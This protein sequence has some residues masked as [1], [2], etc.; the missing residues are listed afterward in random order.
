MDPGPD[1]VDRASREG[2]RLRIESTTADGLLSPETSRDL[3]WRIDVPLSL[4]VGVGLLAAY[5]A[6]VPPGL[7]GGDGA[8][9]MYGLK[10]FQTVHSPG[11]PLYLVLG[12]AVLGLSG[13]TVIPGAHR[14]SALY[15]GVGLSLL[16]WFLREQRVPPLWAFTSCLLLGLAYPI[17]QIAVRVEVYSLGL[18]F[19]TGSLLLWATTRRLKRGHRLFGFWVGLSLLH[20]PLAVLNVL[21]FAHATYRDDGPRIVPI[22]LGAAPILLYGL[23]LVPVTPFPLNWP[24]PG[25]VG[26]LVNHVTAPSFRGFVLERG[27]WTLPVQAGRLVGTHVVAFPGVVLLV[28]LAGYLRL[29]RHWKPLLVL[30]VLFW[31]LLVVYDVPDLHHFA[32]PSLVLAA[33]F[34]AVGFQVLRSRAGAVPTGAVVLVGLVCVYLY[35]VWFPLRYVYRGHHY[36]R[37]FLTDVSRRVHHGVVF[38]DWSRYTILRYGQLVED[39]LH[40]V[41]LISPTPDYQ[42]WR[43]GI[44]SHLERGIPVY[45]T[46]D[47]E[48]LPEGVS[49]KQKGPVYRVRR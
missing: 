2:G 9:L 3:R 48:N 34:L 19:L 33:G 13:Q 7:V 42:G 43:Q 29:P 49:L 24:Q 21:L 12:R 6:V 46:V 10:T 39:R 47:Y 31:G 44:A 32:T 40:R 17:W 36:P 14:L 20:H 38:S 1:R 11:Y 8:E 23:L 5:C 26:D 28:L 37:R 22:L 18:L 27:W 45:L 16:Y 15:M 41:D 25:D 35:A 4:L 30:Q